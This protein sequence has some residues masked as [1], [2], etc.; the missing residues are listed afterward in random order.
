MAIHRTAIIDPKAELDSSV[1]VGAYAII[2]GEVKI[3]PETRVYPHA[4]ISGWVE[5]GP[6]CAI[7][8][9][10]VIGHEAQSRDATPERSYVRIGEGTIIRE[11]ASVHRSMYPEGETVLGKN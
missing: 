4:Y 9:Y 1:E 10:A 3:G 7:H 5:I 8:P 6:R 11:G 2:E